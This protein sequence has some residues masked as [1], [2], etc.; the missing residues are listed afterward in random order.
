MSSPSDAVDVIQSEATDRDPPDRGLR[1]QVPV[2]TE[3]LVLLL[4]AMLLALAA[5]QGREAAYGSEAAGGARGAPGAHPVTALRV[6][7]DPNNLPFSNE[8]GEG[9]EN[10]IASLIASDLGMPVQYAWWPQRRGFVRNTL[11]AGVCDVVMEVPSGY[12]MTA[13]TAPYY[14]STYVFVTRADR[15]LAI[16]SFD[17]PALR[18]LRIGIHMMGDDYANSPAAGALARRGLARQIVPYMIYGDYS[19][20]DPP[21]RLI[22]AVAMD[23]VDV[24]VAWGPLAGY[25]A[26]R[27]PV[28][29]VLTP[30]AA[31]DPGFAYSMSLG[32]RRG[33]GTWRSTLD[34]ELVR[35]RDDI[36]RILEEY[37]VPLMPVGER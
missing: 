7:A 5:S 10:R 27:S 9:F 33:D 36:R 14:R 16:R 11:E 1:F 23:S 4:P 18:H 3:V 17:D 34:T 25:F 19:Q 35:R 31:P 30:V 26:K 24:A 12:E 21:A 22:R 32:V 8:K 15:R 29:L 2:Q 28:R 13:H 37:G 20:P 6:C